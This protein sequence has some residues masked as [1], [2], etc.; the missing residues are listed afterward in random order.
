MFTFVHVAPH[1]FGSFS[2]G[3]ALVLVCPPHLFA[4]VVLLLRRER[5]GWFSQDANRESPAAAAAAAAA[6]LCRLLALRCALCSNFLGQGDLFC[7]VCPQRLA[8]SRLPAGSCRGNRE[9]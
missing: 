7:F 1:V 3:A 6:R 4:S 2:A 9:A 5:H 8:A